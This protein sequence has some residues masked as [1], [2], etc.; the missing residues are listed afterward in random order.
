VLGKEDCHT[1]LASSSP[2]SQRASVSIRDL[3]AVNKTQLGSY[4]APF[5]MVCNMHY[6]TSQENDTASTS[7]PMASMKMSK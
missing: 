7:A 3:P 5:S 1:F 4:T 2:P 6:Q